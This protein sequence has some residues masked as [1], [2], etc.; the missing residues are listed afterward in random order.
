MNYDAV[1]FDVDDT[2]FDHEH[3]RIPP[4]HMEALGRLQAAGMK[5]CLASGRCLS[6]MEDLGVIDAFDW[7]GIVA[8]NGCF[9]YAENGKLIF[10]DPIPKESADKVF[11]VC[12]ERGVPVFAG[13]N[14]DLVTIRDDPATIHLFKAVHIR[15]VPERE[16]RDGDKFA[17]M[18]LLTDDQTKI[19]GLEFEGCRMLHNL[20]CSEF[21]RDTQ[22][23]LDGI[24]RLM[25]HFGLKTFLAFGD[26]VNDLEM[27]EGADMGVAMAN[28]M[29]EVLEKIS[30]HCG[31]V[32]EGG[33]LPWLTDHHII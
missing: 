22:T 4:E 12:K 17:V 1:F 31:P 13:G 10:E 18:S 11:E 23:K 33:I 26:S 6:L 7:D 27:L 29:P 24:H 14:T 16:P 15:D 5:V 28:S 20:W 3:D 21:I 32:N 19:E 2:L 9:V 25:D 8:G 30:E